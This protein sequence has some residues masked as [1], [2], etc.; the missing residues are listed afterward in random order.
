[1]GY[2]SGPPGASADELVRMADAGLSAHEAISA[3]TTG[4]ARALGLADRGTLEVG[5][6][7]DLVIVDGDPLADPRVL[8]DRSRI[9]LVVRDGVIAGAV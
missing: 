6:R 1:M 8:A 7:A 4:S 2:D 9:R 3:A 5:R